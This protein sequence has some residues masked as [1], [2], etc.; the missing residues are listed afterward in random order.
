M[1]DS[2]PQVTSRGVRLLA[3]LRELYTRH[4]TDR[5]PTTTVLTELRELEEAPWGELE[6]KPLDARRLAALLR[7]Y[8]VRACWQTLQAADW[9]GFG[10][11]AGRA[12]P[13]RG[14][15]GFPLV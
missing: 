11:G 7:R 6:G 15:G 9:S 13:H 14:G 10:A 8:G 2:G 4:D 5:L 3:D 12:S 1:L